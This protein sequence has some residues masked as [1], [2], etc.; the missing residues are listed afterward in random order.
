MVLLVICGTVVPSSPTCLAGRVVLVIK[1]LIA[2]I[3]VE[4][5]VVINHFYQISLTVEVRLLVVGHR[6]LRVVDAWNGGLTVK[7]V[8]TNAYLV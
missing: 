8:V 5:A 7:Y 6:R 1:V 3:L 2:S 4:S